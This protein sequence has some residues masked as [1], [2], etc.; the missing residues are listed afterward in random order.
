MRCVLF[1][2][3]NLVYDTEAMFVMENMLNI[4]HSGRNVS[5]AIL[6]KREQGIERMDSILTRGRS[7]K[8]TVTGTVEQT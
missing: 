4:K 8:L 3:G 7:M 6:T 5:P 1:T 2:N